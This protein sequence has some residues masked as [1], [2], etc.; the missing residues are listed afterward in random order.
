MRRILLL[1]AALAMAQAAFAQG[2]ACA[3]L[4]RATAKNFEK[5]L[6]AFLNDY[7]YQKQG[8]VHDPSV[9]TS[10]GVHPFVKVY[11][12]P[13]MWS[14]MTTGGRQGDVPEGAMLVKEQYPSATQSLNEWTIMVK[15]AGGSYD[16]WYWA[17]L[18]P[19]STSATSTANAD[20]GGCPEAAFPYFGFGMYCL[21]CHASAA[22]GTSTFATTAHVFGKTS[23]ADFALPRFAAAA[24]E[25]N[26]HHRLA[27]HAK[28][29]PAAVPK[30]CM[31]DE[32]FDH[33]VAQPKSRPLEHFVTSNQCA[34][35]HDATGS[36]SPTTKDLPRMLWP[37]ALAPQMADLS[38]NGEWRFSMMG[39]S[40][41][42]PIFFSQLS[43]E[44]AL[45]PRLEGHQKDAKEFVQDTCLH[46]H[47]VMGQRQHQMDTGKF[48]TRDELQNP[49]S[50]YGALARDGVSCAACHHIAPQG[51]G[52]PS[53]FTGD[54]HL[55]PANELYGPYNNNVATVPMKN[56]LGAEPKA[57]T[58]NQIESSKLCGSCH[59]VVLPVYE[60]TGKQV[61]RDGKPATFMEQATYP[62]WLNSS[63]G[64]QSCQ[65]CHMPRT[66][67]GQ[68][69]AY[70][71]ANIE[72]NTFPAVDFRAPDSD[73]TLT[74]RN[75]YHRHTL[76]GINVFALEMF[77]Q[78]RTEL[79]LYKTNPML[80]DPAHTTS[81]IDTA[82]ESSVEMA[83]RETATVSVSVS[84]QS[85][86]LV[87][88][89]RVV[90]LVGH[91][92]PSGVGFRRAFLN[93][94]VL[95]GGGKVI[96]ESGGTTPD[97]RIVDGKGK[98]LPT[99]S[100]AGAQQR[101]QEHFW[102]RNPIQRTD[103]VQIYEELVVNPEGQLTT[104][105]IAIDHKVKDN[106]LLPKGWSTAGPFAE[107]TAA[108]GVCVKGN[109]CD[110]DYTNGS[111]AN[112]VRYEIPLG[113]VPNAASV[114]AT[115][116]Y[117]SIPPYYLEERASQGKGTDTDRLVRFAE[118]LKV[119]GTAIQNWKLAI[120]S[121][122]GR[123]Q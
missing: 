25:D 1:V 97:G 81:G 5:K 45:H 72:D 90:N 69:L 32:S 61:V 57:T 74:T 59:T 111:G 49:D 116:Y 107:E 114:R 53:T 122:T 38:P 44:N 47:G 34:G 50:P 93:F 76:L 19:K 39:L 37:D 6:E 102:Q 119:E 84:Q 121:A 104:S 66:Y 42:D 113:Q 54:F 28:A 9:R 65:D 88:D 11:Y 36:L 94:Q 41:R 2:N 89:V 48:L 118:K 80:R 83:S 117:Q 87:A 16:G 14:W 64:N 96:W 110:V 29:D 115:L 82:I 106:R 4:P 35:C 30:H 103:Q 79:G 86:A 24:P 78:F 8:W 99:E 43:S 70:K 92:F 85:T 10:D 3:A 33:V 31:V 12:S 77:R 60:A 100:F 52:E 40:G 63:F 13:A 73:I 55:G 98:V 51:L 112:T 101:F 71:I 123:V 7:C 68:P 27:G 120:A 26:I 46:C 108:V 56:I 21:N 109:V 23:F 95:D 91:N 62:E 18:S 67:K 17:D 75:N 22:K 58:E 15:D 20:T 105:F